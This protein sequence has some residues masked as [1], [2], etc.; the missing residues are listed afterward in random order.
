MSSN[1][2]QNRVRYFRSLA[3]LENTTEFEEHLH[4]EFPVAASEFPEGV[5]RRRWMKLMGASLA[6]GGA[7]GCRYQ[8]EQI[9]A[10]VVRPEN[11]VAGVPNYF[12]TNFEWAGRVMHLLA[13]NMD[14]RPIKLDGNPQHPMYASSEQKDF[15]DGKDAKFASAGT[16]VFAQAAVLSLYDPDRL[17]RVIRKQ[18]GRSVDSSWAAAESMLNELRTELLKDEGKG[19]AVLFDATRSPSLRRKLKEL[20]ATFPQATISELKSVAYPNQEKV[21][22]SVAGGGELVHQLD[23]A[24]IIVALDADLLGS[25]EHA[26]LYTRQ[27][28][29]NRTPNSQ[30]NRLYCVESQYSVTGGSADVRLALNSSKLPGFVSA[31]EAA[32]DAQ[33]GG[34]SADI[35]DSDYSD[36]SYEAKVARVVQVIARDLVANQGASLVAVG[37]HHSEEVQLAGL[38]LNAKLGNIGK[39]VKV[40]QKSDPLAGSSVGLAELAARISSGNVKRILVLGGNPVFCGPTE[41]RLSE[42]LKSAE[43]IYLT[44]YEDETAAI[45]SWVLPATHPLETWGDVLSATGVY[46]VC[47]PQI[48]PLLNGHSALEV[49]GVLIGRPVPA[50]QFVRETVTELSSGMFTD[51]QWKQLLHD[52]FVTMEASLAA[53]NIDASQKLEAEAGFGDLLKD[54]KAEVLLLPSPSVYDGRLANNAWLQELPQPVTKLTWD[55]AL[56][57]SPRTA[58]ALDLKQGELA[59]VNHDAVGVDLPVFIVPGVADGSAI[60]HI[61]YGR[62][63]A[64]SVGNGVGHSVQALRRNPGSWLLTGAEIRGTTRPYKLSTTQDHF[65][66][67]EL[68]LSEIAKRAPTLVREGTLESYQSDPKFAHVEMHHKIESLWK[69]P[70]VNIDY[71]WGMT[72]DLNKCT[73][74]NA[75]VIAC[76]AENNIAVVGKEQVARGREMHWLRIDRYFHC[77]PD[78]SRRESGFADPVDVTIVHQPL[79]CVH[80]ENAPCEQ[81]C[82]V[83]ATVHTEEGINAMAYNRCVGTRYCANNCPYK[84]RRFNYLN[85]N[86]KYGYHYGWQDYRESVNTKLQSLVLNPEVTVRGRGVMEKCTYCIQRVQNGKIKARAEGDGRVH[87]GDIKSACQEACPTQAIVF[88]DLNDRASRVSQLQADPRSYSMLEELNVKP[89]TKYLARIRNVP[90]ELTMNYQ[91]N[92]LSHGHGAHGDHDME[93][94]TTSAAH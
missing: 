19:F 3:Q 57:V 70:A 71:A 76:Q 59:R 86:T 5:S 34:A 80:C 85:Y 46:G 6:F 87:D 50:M 91:R 14:G 74:C 92:T 54:R 25:D 89:R 66:I 58:K 28:G 94:A 93:H 35:A 9:A 37:P 60:A 64:G 4:R 27:F 77:D 32:V 39:S 13:T 36:L 22:E 65:A 47:Q 42:T 81:V 33:L 63:A 53:V 2:N 11:H 49:L 68:G 8:V 30:M 67:D 55:N 84:V 88:G 29:M 51:N 15:H 75:C 7:A 40:F 72:I 17:D 10:F 1:G 21:L 48:E 44:D 82:P 79:M 62:T 69:N 52:G 23:A 45:S 31:L 83:A 41:F 24:K 26:V 12:A 18:E 78:R 20:S 61:G 43:I 73:G 16:D 90:K 56:I 38:R